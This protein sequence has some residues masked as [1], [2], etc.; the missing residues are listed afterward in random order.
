MDF[1]LNLASESVAHAHP[2]E[3]LIVAPTLSLCDVLQLMQA[4]SRGSVM[5]CVAGGSLV[6]ILTERDVVKL[7]AVGADLSMPIGRVMVRDLVRLKSS[8]TVGQAILAMAQGGYRRL[9]VVDDRGR[10]VGVL[11]VSRILEYLVEHFPQVV[12]TLPPQPHQPSGSGG[13]L[14]ALGLQF[15]SHK[16]A[17]GGAG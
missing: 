2:E 17:C 14:G 8:D 7:L 10:P 12:Y 4:R 1:Q 3:P 11:G 5:V 15:G 13:G 16:T 6:G 9:P